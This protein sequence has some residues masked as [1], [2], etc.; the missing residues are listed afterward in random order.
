M[1]YPRVAMYL[2]LLSHNLGA[3]FSRLKVLQQFSSDNGVPIAVKQR[4]IN[5]ARV[6]FDLETYHRLTVKMR[7]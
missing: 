3:P 1:V 7:T 4:H 5:N 2:T 6:L